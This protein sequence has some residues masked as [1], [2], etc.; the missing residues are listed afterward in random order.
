MNDRVPGFGDSRQDPLG[1]LGVRRWQSLAGNS[2]DRGPKAALRDNCEDRSGLKS[3]GLN[4]LPEMREEGC[5]RRTLSRRARR[6]SPSSVGFLPDCDILG[7][8]D[9]WSETGTCTGGAFPDIW[10]TDATH[11]P[12]SHKA[13]SHFQRICSGIPIVRRL[14]SSDM[15]NYRHFPADRL[16]RWGVPEHGGPF[17]AGELNLRG[18]PPHPPIRLQ[19]HP[20][21]GKFVAWN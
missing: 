6:F 8:S 15:F 9:L 11:C 4:G 3:Q 17:R 18:P 10:R 20:A 1:E 16:L 2:R 5:R 12:W 19:T 14:T 7:R 13:R 21:H